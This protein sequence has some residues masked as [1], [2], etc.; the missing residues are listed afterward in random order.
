LMS[1]SGEILLVDFFYY[2]RYIFYST[3]ESFH[4]AKIAILRFILILDTNY[5]DTIYLYTIHDRNCMSDLQKIV[6][7]HIQKIVGATYKKL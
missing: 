2:S 5:L 6:G 7:V 3:E 4:L 1:L